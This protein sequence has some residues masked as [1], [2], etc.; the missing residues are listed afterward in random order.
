[1]SVSIMRGMRDRGIKRIKYAMS[2]NRGEESTSHKRKLQLASQPASLWALSRT[3]LLHI[4]GRSAGVDPNSIESR[5][6]YRLE[7]RG[8]GGESATQAFDRSENQW[9]G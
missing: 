1:M 9:R 8:E 2:L 4:S 7:M 6:G 3:A 5:V